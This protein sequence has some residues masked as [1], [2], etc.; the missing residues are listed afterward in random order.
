M[1]PLLSLIIFL[2]IAAIVLWLVQTIT[3]NLPLTP[4]V[5]SLILAVTALILLVIFLQR[6]GII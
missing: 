6:A 1:E 3:A 5:R 4:V 2:I